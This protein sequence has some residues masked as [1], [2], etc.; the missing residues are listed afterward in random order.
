VQGRAIGAQFEDDRN[1]LPLA[2]F[3]TLDLYFARRIGTG[4]EFFASAENLLNRRYEVALTP[5]RV[6]GPP[7]LWRVG[8]RLG[9]GNQ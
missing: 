5:T 7:L 6:L 3:R 8:A 4:L 9:L 2:G 1:L